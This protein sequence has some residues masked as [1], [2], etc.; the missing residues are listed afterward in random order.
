MILD[1]LYR[2]SSFFGEGR[3]TLASLRCFAVPEPLAWARGK[4][5]NAPLVVIENAATWDTYRRWNTNHECFSAVVYGGGKRF[6]DSVL[7]LREVFAELG[8]RRRVLYFGDLDAA[9][10]RIPRLASVRA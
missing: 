10:L 5:H 1:E 9:G 8:G 3:L 6:I 4:N 7:W 2:G